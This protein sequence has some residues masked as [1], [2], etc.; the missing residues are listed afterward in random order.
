MSYYLWGTRN[1]GNWKARELEGE[2]NVE[3]INQGS[4]EGSFLIISL[5]REYGGEWFLTRRSG[6]PNVVEAGSVLVLVL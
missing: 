3:R 6:H 1:G 2:K 5:E 4:A